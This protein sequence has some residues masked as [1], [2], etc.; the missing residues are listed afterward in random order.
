MGPLDGVTNSIM[1]CLNSALDGNG[2]INVKA[3]KKGLSMHLGKV[4]LAKGKTPDEFEANFK[5]AIAKAKS[6]NT[7]KGGLHKS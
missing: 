7:S 6:E 5:T 4:L 1:G 2:T 3:S